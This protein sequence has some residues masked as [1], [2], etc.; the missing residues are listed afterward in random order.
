MIDLRITKLVIVLDVELE[1]ECCTQELADTYSQ[2]L[3][4][5]DEA[6]VGD[7]VLYEYEEGIET[8]NELLDEIKSDFEYGDYR[9]F[10]KIVK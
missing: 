4:T 8:F 1:D 5:V 9:D 3:Y 6:L 10:G 2:V 7:L